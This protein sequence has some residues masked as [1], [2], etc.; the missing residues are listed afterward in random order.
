MKKILTLTSVILLL[1]LSSSGCIHIH[2]A[3]D[4]LVPK[5]DKT[6]EYIYQSY[7]FSDNLTSNIPLE[8]LEIY[9]EQFPLE[10]KPKT[11]HMRID[12]S[13]TMRSAHELIRIIN[14]TVP[15]DRPGKEYLL[16]LLEQALEYADQR[17]FKVTIKIPESDD[18]K[19]QYRFN[20]TD[21]V[22]VGL[23]SSPKD[24]TW[25]IEVEG[26][27]IGGGSE[28]MGFEYH[29]AFSVDIVLKEI[30]E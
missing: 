23:I 15:D 16:E 30:K 2:L 29:D 1:I 13:I 14:D 22:E 26:A 21:Q 3:K 5:E 11:E 28:S 8:V 7:R 12:I 24:G 18:F 9:D 27:G 6:V 10:V 17:Y 4:L 20:Q 25:I 19:F